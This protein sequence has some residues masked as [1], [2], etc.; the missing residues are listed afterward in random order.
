MVQMG[1]HK[2]TIQQ[3][4]KSRPPTQPDITAGVSQLLTYR[5]QGRD[6]ADTPRDTGLVASVSA[7]EDM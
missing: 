5:E 3:A 1:H 6:L 2:H 4:L 7:P